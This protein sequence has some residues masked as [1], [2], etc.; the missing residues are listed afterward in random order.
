MNDLLLFLAGSAIVVWWSRKPLRQPGSH[1]FWRFFAWEAILGL[2]VLNHDIWGDD[3]YSPHQFASWL[4]MLTS[5][6]LV[7]A[8]VQGLKSEGAAGAQRQDD[9]FYEFEKT[10]QLVRHGV[11]AYI[12][13]PMYASL[14]ALAWGAFCQDPSLAGAGLGG[15]ATLALWLT[16]RSDERECLAYFGDSY[17]E[18]MQQT[19][20]F[21]PY[22]F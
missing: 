10:T 19:R 22:L 20:R 7:V 8:G 18:Y 3:P 2:I 13:H 12:R 14:L 21:I 17:A 11:F 16:A 6:A 5:I 4:L 1:G 9:S 15:V